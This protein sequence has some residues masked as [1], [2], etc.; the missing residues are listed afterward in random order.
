MLLKQNHDRKQ[1]LPVPR[2]RW[3]CW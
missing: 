2:G 3:L 1:Y